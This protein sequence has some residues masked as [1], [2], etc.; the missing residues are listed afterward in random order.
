MIE[1]PASRMPHAANSAAGLSFAAFWL[2]SHLVGIGG[3]ESRH[4]ELSAPA[5]CR[6]RCI[7]RQP[8]SNTLT[9]EPRTPRLTTSI[10][11]ATLARGY[12]CGRSGL[13]SGTSIEMAPK[14][15]GGLAADWLPGLRSNAAGWQTSSSAPVHPDFDIRVA[16]PAQ[17]ARQS[18]ANGRGST[19]AHC[20]Q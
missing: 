11:T 7:L 14:T 19:A 3:G 15:M 20:R 10:L 4:L 2:R 9:A 18:G 1:P 6:N 8:K 13:P 16:E 17:K 12:C 5:F